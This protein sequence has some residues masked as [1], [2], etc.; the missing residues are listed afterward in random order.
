ML[1]SFSHPNCWSQAMM[2]WV[3]PFLFA[4]LTIQSAAA[5]NLRLQQSGV[6][7]EV[8]TE[9]D[10][11]TLC[12]TA[13]DRTKISAQYGVSIESPGSEVGV[14][15]AKLPERIAS[16]DWDFKLP[17]RIDLRTRATAAGERPRVKLGA[18]SDQCNLVTFYFYVPASSAATASIP[19][20]ARD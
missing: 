20:C 5:E 14:W 3:A 8:I 13:D 6:S 16:E 10:K 7:L 9:V 11:V 4:L 19:Y 17:L 18:C 2:R 15:R 1:A 12:I